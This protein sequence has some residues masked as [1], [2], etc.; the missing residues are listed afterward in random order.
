TVM[1]SCDTRSS[2]FFNC[3]LKTPNKPTTRRSINGGALS[4]LLS[5]ARRRVSGPSS[6]A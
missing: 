1:K 3:V 4:Q 2:D 6:R 5:W